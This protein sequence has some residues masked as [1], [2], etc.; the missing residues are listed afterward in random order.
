[1]SILLPL[2]RS[3]SPVII[4]LILSPW[5]CSR[6]GTGGGISGEPPAAGREEMRSPILRLT[7]R[8]LEHSSAGD[9]SQDFGAIKV[10]AVIRRYSTVE[11]LQEIRRLAEAGDEPGFQKGFGRLDIASV[12]YP[13]AGGL[14]QRCYAAVEQPSPQGVRILLFS[15]GIVSPVMKMW[16]TR[17]TEYRLNQKHEGEGSIYRARVLITEDGDIVLERISPSIPSQITNVRPIK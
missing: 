14:R 5:S 13:T 12:E 8:L 3:F 15:E 10:R 6:V 16:S 4:I 9:A 7:G 1:M 11:E 17:I 2:A